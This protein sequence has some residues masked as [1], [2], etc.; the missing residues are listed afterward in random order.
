MQS[1]ILAGGSGTR[2]WPMSRKEFPKQFLKIDSEK[3]FLCQS[4]ERLLAA[5]SVDN[6]HVITNEDYKFHVKDELN[7]V[8]T[9]LSDGV[10]IE[11]VGRNTAPA[12]ALAVKYCLDNLKSDLDEIVFISPSDQVMRPISKFTDALKDVKEAARKGF[13]VTL[14]IK[15][16]CPETGYGYIKAGDKINGYHEV[17]EFTE[18]PDIENAKRYIESGEYFWNSGMFAF[19]IKTIL[20]E[21]KKHAPEIYERFD[22]SYDKFVSNFETMPSIS[23]D[24]SIMEKS[25]KIAMI[26]LEITWSDVGSWDSLFDIMP[27][28]ENNNVIDGDVVTIDTNNSLIFSSKKLVSTLGVK[29]L[30]IVETDDALLV[31]KQGESQRTRELVDAL[32]KQKRKEALEHTTTYRPWGDYTIL[33]GGERYKIK[34]I[35]VKPHQSISLQLHRQRSEHWIV[36]S[37]TAKVTI[38][39]KVTIVNENE[40][41]YVPKTK[42]HRLENPSDVDL[43]LIEI[44]SGNYI[45][46]DDI[47]RFEDIYGRT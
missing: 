41:V 11:P 35:I 4:I 44:Q 38:D 10:I 24:Y 13:I 15:P 45:E 27:H 31:A 37:G 12:I 20:A 39:D 9:V 23:I 29:D 28:D 42:K 5:D 16:T 18:K 47:E 21:F 34:R 32:K 8:S 40:S 26:P 25:D 22:Q 6:I 36:V 19:S 30:I 46:E 33:G 1:F 2:L 43:E 17:I 14:G 3:S 7:N